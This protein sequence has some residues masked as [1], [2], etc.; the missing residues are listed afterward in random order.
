MEDCNYLKEPTEAHNEELLSIDFKQL[1]NTLILPNNRR[2]LFLWAGISIVVGIIVALS[3]PKAYTVTAG[4]AP[5]LSTSSSSKLGTITNILGMGN[6][7]GTTEAIYPTLYPK[8]AHSTPFV[9]Q[10]LES[11]VTMET[12]QQCTLQDYMEHHTRHPW[13]TTALNGIRNIFRSKQSLTNNDSIN[14]YQFTAKEYALMTSLNRMVGVSVDKKTMEITLSTTAQDPHVAASMSKTVSKLL[15]DAVTDYRTDKAKQTVE[16]YE[17]L[18]TDAESEYHK[19]QSTYANYVDRHQGVVLLSVKVE[20]DRLQNEMNLK[21]QLYNQIATELQN[22]RAKV[23]L[24]TPVFTEIVPPTIPLIPSKPKKKVIVALFL[25]LGLAGGCADILWWHKKEADKLD[26][27]VSK[28][29][30]Q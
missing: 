3:I 28:N 11:T 17:K 20:Q 21:Y 27:E 14:P 16:Y 10:M 30:Q 19:A 22:A 26:N 1:Y 6:L 9:K 29:E 8:I 18:Y 4:L 12:G 7:T 2:R 13:W 23:Q 25:I 5:E 15:K 24:E